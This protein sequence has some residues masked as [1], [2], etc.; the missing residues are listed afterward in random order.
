[1]AS[2]AYSGRFSR[3]IYNADLIEIVDM[4][5]QHRR[6]LGDLDL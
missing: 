3:R 4:D 1:M 6:Q 2:A 5:D